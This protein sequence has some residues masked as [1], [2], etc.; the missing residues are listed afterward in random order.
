M[1][2]AKYCYLLYLVIFETLK[3]LFLIDIKNR[4]IRE[5]REEKYSLL[6]LFI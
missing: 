4:R 3:H 1:F 6:R 2:Q 5:I